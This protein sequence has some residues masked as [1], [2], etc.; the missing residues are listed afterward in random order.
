MALTT[1]TADTEMHP[2]EAAVSVSPKISE[3]P[4]PSFPHLS[5]DH[6][7]LIDPTPYVG[8]PHK[9]GDLVAMRAAPLR[10]GWASRRII[11]LFNDSE[12][13]HAT[14]IPTS[15]AGALREFNII[16]RPTKP[17]AFG[18]VTGTEEG[19]FKELTAE[20]Q[21]IIDSNMFELH[22]II[23]DYK[24]HGLVFTCSKDSLDGHP[25][26]ASRAVSSMGQDVIDYVT[27]CIYSMCI[28]QGDLRDG[29]VY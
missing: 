2:I 7:V 11:Y 3:K 8:G 18:I 20:V 25:K 14:A 17:E 26:W 16:G 23:T 19:A 28:Y 10:P 15:R 12:N 29:S 13:L 9:I 6:F 4:I 24:I 5:R 27:R 22:K 21:A 1:T